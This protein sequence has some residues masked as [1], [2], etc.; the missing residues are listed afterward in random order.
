MTLWM[1]GD[2][3]G[4]AKVPR[5]FGL[6]VKS[7]TVTSVSDAVVGSCAAASATY[8]LIVENVAASDGA[9]SMTKM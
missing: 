3:P 2:V 8:A 4:P 5:I 1:A 9:M 6:D 7:S